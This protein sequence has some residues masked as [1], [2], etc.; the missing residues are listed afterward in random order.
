MA[1]RKQFWRWY[2]AA[3]RRR[4]Y[5]FNSLK[6]ILSEQLLLLG[7][8]N[9]ASNT[10]DFM[11]LSNQ[12][13]SACGHCLVSNCTVVIALKLLL[14]SWL[15]M[16]AAYLSRLYFVVNADYDKFAAARLSCIHMRKTCLCSIIWAVAHSFS[17]TNKVLFWPVVWHLWRFIDYLWP[18]QQSKL[19]AL[20][21][22]DWWYVLAIVVFVSPACS[23]KPL[24]S[25]I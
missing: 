17:D 16:S 14:N 13:V 15:K 23:E 24:L 21:A 11:L 5:H 19:Y 2:S 1:T 7:H 20:G 4:S 25:R 18:W 6:E 9:K 3:V 12:Q 8:E 10:A 22:K